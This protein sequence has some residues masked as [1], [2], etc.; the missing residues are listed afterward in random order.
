MSLELVKLPTIPFITEKYNFICFISF[1][2]TIVFMILVTLPPYVDLPW[3]KAAMN[4]A[5]VR[6]ASLARPC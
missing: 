5:I 4:P 1:F 6:T 3:H 2:L